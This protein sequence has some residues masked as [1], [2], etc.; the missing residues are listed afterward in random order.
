MNDAL[1]KTLRVNDI[2]LWKCAL[3]VGVSEQTLIRWLRVELTG[4][5]KERV[6]TAIKA[7]TKGGDVQ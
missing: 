3:A 2:P 5:R 7:L 4:E 1:K 6:E